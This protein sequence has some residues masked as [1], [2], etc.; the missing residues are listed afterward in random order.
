MRWLRFLPVFRT[1]KPGAILPMEPLEERA[2]DRLRRERA[3][4][5]QTFTRKDQS[6]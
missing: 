1:R 6:R 5:A 4:R 2:L 3:R